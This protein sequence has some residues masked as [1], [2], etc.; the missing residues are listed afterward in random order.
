[1]SVKYDQS[2]FEARVAR[3]ANFKKKHTNYETKKADI[4]TSRTSEFFKPINYDVY[5]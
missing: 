1:M 2:D 5:I 4:K 3:I